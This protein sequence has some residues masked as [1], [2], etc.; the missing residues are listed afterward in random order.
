MVVSSSFLD[1][2]IIILPLVIGE[3]TLW[4]YVNIFFLTKL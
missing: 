3:E 2:I 4:D 1:F